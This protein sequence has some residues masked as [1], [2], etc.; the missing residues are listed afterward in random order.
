MLVALVD[1]DNAFV[2]MHWVGETELIER[3]ADLEGAERLGDGVHAR[4]RADARPRPDQR[5][6]LDRRAADRDDRA[7]HRR[8]AEASPIEAFLTLSP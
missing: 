8:A 1:G 5:A 2:G 6:G 3:I 4:H 7:D